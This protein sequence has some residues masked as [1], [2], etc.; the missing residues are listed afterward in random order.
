MHPWPGVRQVQ[1]RTAFRT[2]GNGTHRPLSR[3]THQTRLDRTHLTALQR[4][5]VGAGG[6]GHRG[7]DPLTGDWP[8]DPPTGLH[9][10]LS[11]SIYTQ[12]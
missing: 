6:A 9:S 11:R 7:P 3:A 10:R 8:P 2:D 5:S 4:Q 12:P 1:G